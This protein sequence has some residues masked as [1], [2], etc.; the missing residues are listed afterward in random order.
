VGGARY[1]SALPHLPYVTAD[2]TRDFGFTDAE[3]KPLYTVGYKIVKTQFWNR[4]LQTDI[5]LHT[6]VFAFQ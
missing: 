4:R 5:Y 3:V 2:Q 6:S 1:L